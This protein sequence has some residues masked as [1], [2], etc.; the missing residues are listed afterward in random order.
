MNNRG[1]GFG[2]DACIVAEV[3][4]P[5]DG[6]RACS[7]EKMKVQFLISPAELRNPL[8]QANFKFQSRVFRIN[9]YKKLFIPVFL[10]V[11]LLFS[12]Y[13]KAMEEKEVELSPVKIV[14]FPFKRAVISTIINSSV[15]EYMFKEG[16]SF[17]EG[18]IIV[19]LDD[20]IYNQRF[21]KTK[22]YSTFATRAYQNNLKLAEKGGIGQYELEKSKFENEAAAAEMKIAQIDLDACIIKAP[23]S[24]RLVK[25]IVKEYEFVRIGQPVLEIINDYQLLAVMHLP[26]TQRESVK[27][28]QEIQFRIDETGASCNGKIYEISAEIDP[29]SRTFELK[30]LIDNKDQKLSAGMSGVME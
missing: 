26:S 4:W 10:P 23:F 16:E 9:A 12:P 21:I 15:K 29:R 5:I 28:E 13:T 17:S 7:K 6:E 3:D 19:K 11:A 1:K 20:A 24:G 25:K 2:F 18:D 27:N 30:I 8:G 14:L 22:T